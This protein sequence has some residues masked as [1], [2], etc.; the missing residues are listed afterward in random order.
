MSL[1]GSLEQSGTGFTKH[2]V[3][4]NCPAWA[5][6]VCVNRKILLSFFAVIEIRRGADM[7]F[8]WVLFWL[9][10]FAHLSAIFV[11]PRLLRR[12]LKK[13]FSR[14]ILNRTMIAG[15]YSAILF[16]LIASLIIV[17]LETGERS[18]AGSDGARK[19]TFD[20]DEYGFVDIRGQVHVHSYLSHDSKGTLE[21]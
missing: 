16:I 17:S 7:M 6:F 3:F 19:S 18:V 9:L 15:S 11:W 5:V 8:L 4:K 21:E 20:V 12:V 1:A 2:K 14:K 10:I 13:E